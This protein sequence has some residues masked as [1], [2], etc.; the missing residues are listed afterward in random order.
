MND[1]TNERGMTLLDNPSNALLSTSLN[2]ALNSRAPS[3]WTAFSGM[4]KR[5]L[6]IRIRQ[7]SE[8]ANPLFFFMMV[9]TLFPLGVSSQADQLQLIAPGV[10]WIAALL[11]TLLA[12]DGLVQHDFDDGTLEQ[13]LLSSQPLVILVLAKVVGHWLVTGCLLTLVA[14]LF[15]LMLFLEAEQLRVLLLT[16][17]LGTPTLSFIS[18]IGAALTVGLNKGGV[19][20]ALIALPLYIPVL[21]FATSAIQAVVYQQSVAGHLAILAAMLVLAVTFA[22]FA[23]AAALRISVSG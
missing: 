8:L 18:A 20:I 7:R 22:P 11:A 2:G 1:D 21:I 12:V 6:L 19:L 9:L 23:I 13:L 17:L 15:G 4:L 10:V 5:E 3:S 16:L 14:P